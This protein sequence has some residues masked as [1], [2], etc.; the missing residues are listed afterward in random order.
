MNESGCDTCVWHSARQTSTEGA[1][2]TSDSSLAV[3][4]VQ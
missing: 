4:N 2:V 1:P 3:E